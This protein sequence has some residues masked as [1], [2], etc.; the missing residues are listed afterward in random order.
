M[1]PWPEHAWHNCRSP[2]KKDDEEDVSVNN[3]VVVATV[4]LLFSTVIITLMFSIVENKLRSESITWH[5][6]SP[7][8]IVSWKQ[9]GPIIRKGKVLVR[10]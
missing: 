6:H 3:S 5:L 9:M 1:D 7:Q 4:M 10:F 2:V 8:Q